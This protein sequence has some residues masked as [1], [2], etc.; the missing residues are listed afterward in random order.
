M[1]YLIDT[2]SLLS[3]VR[4]YL[5]FDRENLVFARLKDCFNKESIILIESVKE[6]SK[7]VSKGLIM[8]K[9]IF[10]ES[11]PVQKDI[12]LITSKDHTKIDDHWVNKQETKKLTQTEYDS[13]KEGMIKGADFQLILYAL[14][15]NEITIITEETAVSNDNKISKKIPMICKHENIHCN[16]LPDMLLSLGLRITYNW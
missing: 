7:K 6:Q 15:N 5:P 10:L 9:L 13:Q 1:K 3:L 14:R 4:Y 8:K 11:L 16:T 2:S 12:T